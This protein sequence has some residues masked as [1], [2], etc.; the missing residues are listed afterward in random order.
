MR[1][2]KGKFITIEGVEGA[3]KSTALAFIAEFLEKNEINFIQTREP[4][5]TEIGEKI[6][7]LLLDKNHSQIHPDA[8]LLLMFAARV[9]HWHELIKPEL[10]AGSW[11]LSDRFTDSS[12]AYQGAGRGINLNRLKEL[13]SWSMGE[14]KPDKTLLLDIDPKLG[15]KRVKLRGASDRF[16]SEKIEFF[17]R[18]RKGFLELAANEPGRFAIIDS[19][20]TI[21]N[22]QSQIKKILEAML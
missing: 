18:V 21:S 9:Q 11:V 14:I 4:G 2:L 13:D 12:F 19:A 1:N 20:E 10:A 22:T 7:S 17:S 6:R 16:E 8:E 15:M 3:G 5:G